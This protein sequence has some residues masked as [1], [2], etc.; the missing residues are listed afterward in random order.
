MVQT[1]CTGSGMCD[2]RAA[3]CRCRHKGLAVKVITVIAVIAASVDGEYA[4]TPFLK[5]AGRTEILLLDGT[6]RGL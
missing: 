4:P 5:K 3:A 2:V 1:K 6:T